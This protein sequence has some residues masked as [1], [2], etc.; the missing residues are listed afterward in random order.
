MKRTVLI[1]LLLFASNSWAHINKE[2]SLEQK[3]IFGMVLEKATK[4]EIFSKFGDASPWE[5]SDK[6]HD[7]YLYCYKLSSKQPAWAILGFGLAWSF[8]RL[9]SIMVTESKSD[10]A[11]ECSDTDV[12]LVQMKTDGGIY[13]GMPKQ[14]ALK[15]IPDKPE[16]KGEKVTYSYESYQKYKEPKKHL[17]SDFTY[18]GEWHYGVI[19]YQ[20]KNNMLENYYIWVSGEPDW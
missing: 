11:G 2:I 7:S 9:D 15:L 17:T 5:R 19:E 10:I 4:Q 16:I 14:E 6:K 1:I 13:L 18:I 20:F 12:T 3:S 8:K